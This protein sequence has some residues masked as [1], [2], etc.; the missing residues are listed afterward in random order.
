MWKTYTQTHHHNPVISMLAS[1][2]HQHVILE[3]IQVTLEMSMRSLKKSCQIS[4]IPWTLENEIIF[5][6]TINYMKIESDIPS[7]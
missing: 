4:G 6:P 2:Y 7:S 3:Y 1:V 5:Q